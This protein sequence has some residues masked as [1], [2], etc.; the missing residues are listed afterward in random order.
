MAS[1]V[2]HLLRVDP[3]LGGIITCG[4]RLEAV[5][6]R[7]PPHASLSGQRTPWG[8]KPG[9]LDEGGCFLADLDILSPEAQ[10]LLAQR[11]DGGGCTLVAASTEPPWAHLADRVAFL[12]SESAYQR[13]QPGRPLSLHAAIAAIAAAAQRLEVEG[14]RAEV[15][16]LKAAR[17]IARD[18]GRIRL[19]EGDV[20]EALALVLAPRARVRQQ[21]RPEEEPAPGPQ[22]RREERAEAEAPPLPVP[23]PPLPDAPLRTRPALHGA[24]VRSVPGR[25]RKG[26]LDLSA[27]LLA[28]LPWQKLRGNAGFPPAI[29][30]ADLRWH[31]RRPRQGRLIIFGV[32]SSGSM[33]ARR[34]GQA[35]GAVLK[36]LQEAYRRRDQVALIAASGREPRLLL[37]PARAVEQAR[38]R[39]VSLPAGGATPLAGALLQARALALRARRRDGRASLLLL[40]T[41]GRANQPLPGGDRTTVREELK[42]AS[43]AVR[44]AG[45]ES[46]VLGQ[47]G[48]EALELAHWLGGDFQMIG[49]RNL[50]RTF[51]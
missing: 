24:P 35:K 9:L 31:L 37:P 8:Y 12:V 39:L 34:L 5:G 45:V 7:V 19:C 38:R 25:R 44:A 10:A 42:K 28:A 40:L 2:L 30:S 1:R 46:V 18:S 15:F 36:L 29:R 49:T 20:A 23:M 33:G 50:A 13:P 22:Q 43:L 4:F 32:D 3:S 51:Q 47:P 6:R 16:A 27:T 17:A 11:L 21:A 14:H 48:S 41:D 26:T